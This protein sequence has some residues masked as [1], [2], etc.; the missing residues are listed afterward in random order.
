MSTKSGTEATG[1]FSPSLWRCSGI[2]LA[3]QLTVP[4]AVTNAV[5]HAESDCIKTLH[6]EVSALTFKQTPGTL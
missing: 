5:D 1:V 2:T 3:H 6:I 4:Y